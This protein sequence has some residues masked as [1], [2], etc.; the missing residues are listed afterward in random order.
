MVWEMGYLL[1][2]ESSL[3]SHGN[4]LHSWC[5]DA[6]NRV[7]F[8]GAHALQEQICLQQS[9]EVPMQTVHIFGREGS[10]MLYP[11][12]TDPIATVYPKLG[13]IRITITTGSNPKARTQQ[14]GHRNPIAAPSPPRR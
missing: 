3:L 2:K 9:R 14:W 4:V 10:S 13:S 1:R 11:L 6:Q 8:H 7:S 12:F 5:S